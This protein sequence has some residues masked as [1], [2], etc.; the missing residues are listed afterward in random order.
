MTTKRKNPIEAAADKLRAKAGMPGVAQEIQPKRPVHT[1]E[2]ATKQLAE[3]NDL[4]NGFSLR[5]DELLDKQWRGAR[6]SESVTMD[7]RVCRVAGA[8]DV[9]WDALEAARVDASR[10]L[11]DEFHTE[12]D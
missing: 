9:L 10:A 6:C 8:M 11:E 4:L 7:R 2:Q 1:I 5:F 3:L 12:D